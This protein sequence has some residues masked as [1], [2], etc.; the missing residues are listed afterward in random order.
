MQKMLDM[1]YYMSDSLQYNYMVLLSQ[2]T[3]DLHNFSGHSDL[4]TSF[5]MHQ[6][7][8]L[9]CICIDT[10]TCQFH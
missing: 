1:K 2:N 3:S 6:I 7:R 8:N 9:I 10:S 5:C 4:L